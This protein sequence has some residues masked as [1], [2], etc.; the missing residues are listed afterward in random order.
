MRGWD[1]ERVVEAAGS[2]SRSRAWPCAEAASWRPIARGR[3]TE[4]PNARPCSRS[5]GANGVESRGAWDPSPWWKSSSARSLAASC[6][7][8][9]PL[10]M[11]A[12]ALSRSGETDYLL[13]SFADPG[14]AVRAA[15]RLLQERQQRFAV[16]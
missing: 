16:S 2:G 9:A 3:R 13:P 4:P 8:S 11:M 6:S 1:P 12:A 5:R 7:S 15:Y 14:R 10:A